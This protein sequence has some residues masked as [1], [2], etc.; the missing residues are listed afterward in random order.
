MTARRKLNCD[1]A[2]EHLGS[3]MF[4]LCHNENAT[5][6]GWGAAEFNLAVDGYIEMIQGFTAGIQRRDDDNWW[7]DCRWEISEKEMRASDAELTRVMLLDP[8]LAVAQADVDLV[9]LTIAEECPDEGN[10]D[11]WEETAALRAK[12]ARLNATVERIKNGA[13][14]VAR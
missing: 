6:C 9:A 4:D 2:Y 3:L 10:L 8:P 5:T 13:G 12:L 7:C 14:E 1:E 11:D